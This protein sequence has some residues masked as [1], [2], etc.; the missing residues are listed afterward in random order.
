MRAAAIAAVA[1]SGAAMAEA[2]HADRGGSIVHNPKP[3]PTYSATPDIGAGARVIKARAKAKAA[4]K[5]RAK[6]RMRAKGK[7]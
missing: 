6:Q 1:L 7:R 4:S 5:A 3:A 2:P